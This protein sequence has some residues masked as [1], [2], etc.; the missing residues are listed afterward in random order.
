MANLPAN[1]QVMIEDGRVH[2]KSLEAAELPERIEQLKDRI[3]SRWPPIRIED[4]LIEVDAW[5]D[6]SRFFRTL[7]GRRPS[8]PDFRKGLLATLI[9]KGC[10]IGMVK[11]AALAPGIRPGTL[12]RVGELYLYEDT[13]RH[14]IEHLVK[15]HHAL[16]IAQHLGDKTI[17]MSDGMRVRSRVQTLHAAFM[18]QH[19]APGQRAITCYWHVSHQGP[20][21]AAQVFGNDRDAAYVLDQILHIRSELPI[22]EHY[23]DTHGATEITFALA[24]AFGVEYAPRIKLIHTQQMYHPPGMKILGPLKAHFAGSAD[25]DLIRRHWDDCVRVLAS[26]RHGVTGAVLLCQ[27]LSSYAQQNPL[28]RALREIGRLYRTRFMLRYYDEPEWRRR[29]NAGL[30]R[31]ENFNNLARH[32]FFARRGE[33]W[34]REFEEQLNRAC[35]LLILANACILWNAVHLE[36]D[37]P[38]SSISG[39]RCAPGGLPAHFTLCLRAHRP[40]WPVLLQLATQA[41]QGCVYPRSPVVDEQSGHFL[42]VPGNHP[43]FRVWVKR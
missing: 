20:G 12:R 19:F 34:E 22:H 33:N 14:V 9:A 4:L 37:V 8:L 35:S 30:D 31:M 11:M 5:T 28:Y 13:L 23:T 24:Y 43:S 7:R 29:I 36:R 1:P 26:I 15:T 16:P 39:L 40:V 10:N 41:T 3:A 42:H 18:P 32:L 38:G 21:Y 27:R 17:S 2:L 6:F 25:L